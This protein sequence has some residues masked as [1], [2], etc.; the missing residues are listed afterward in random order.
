LKRSLPF[1]EEPK[2]TPKKVCMGSP[3]DSYTPIKRN[4]FAIPTQ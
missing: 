2:G 1:P 3:G 4:L